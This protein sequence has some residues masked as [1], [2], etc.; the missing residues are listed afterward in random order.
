MK[1]E[2]EIE[3][4]ELLGFKTTLLLCT[5][6][7]KAHFEGYNNNTESLSFTVN[8]RQHSVCVAADSKEAA[9]RDIALQL[10]SKKL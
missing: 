4:L 6:G 9:L 3:A 1:T 2:Q 5:A 7:H 8:S 10:L